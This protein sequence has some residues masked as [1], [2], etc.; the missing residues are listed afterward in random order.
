[1]ENLTPS[2][3]LNKRPGPEHQRAK[4][5]TL[6]IVEFLDL[7]QGRYQTVAVHDSNNRLKV[8]LKRS[9]IF[10]KGVISPFED[11]HRAFYLINYSEIA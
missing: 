8:T 11:A 5:I 1:M 3:V 6:G 9:D 4:T 2:T 7:V 10:E